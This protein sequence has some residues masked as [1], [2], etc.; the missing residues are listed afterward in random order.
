MSDRITITIPDFALVIL[1]GPSGSGKSSFARRHFLETEIIS[2]DHCRA[3]V[4]DDETDQAASADAFKLLH[5]TAAIR[6]RRRKLTVID[7]TSVHRAHRAN[8]VTLARRY[9]ALPVALVLDID[10]EICHA[11]N[12]E[13]PNRA[14]PID[15]PRS[16]SRALTRSLKRL[17]QEGFRQ[18]HIWRSPEEIDRVTIAREP[19][20]TDCRSETGPFD[21]I[22]DIHG[23][24]DEATALLTR[25]GY[26]IDAFDDAAEDLIRARHPEGRIAFFVGDLCDRGPRNVASLRLVMGM[27]AEGSGRCV[28]GNHDFKLEKWLRGKTTTLSHGLDVTVAELQQ[29]SPDFRDKV[30]HFIAG[31]RSHAWLAGGGLVIAHAGLRQEMHGRDTGTIR[32]F[33]M[34]GE[35]TGEVDEFG[36]PVR[37]EWA[38]SYNGAAEVV[39]GH[40]PMPEARWLNN[41]LCVDTGCVYGNKLTAFRWPEGEIVDVAAKQQYAVPKK[42]LSAN[43]R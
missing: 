28:I 42:P 11:R 36:L 14:F 16:H 25:L 43:A 12:A 20:P 34:F 10:P 4:S 2:S 6:L 33:A 31:L 32:A 18:I 37:L 26:T 23:C 7:A 13:R 21:I 41:T 5:E 17:Q 39:F 9:H 3:L 24:F 38:R 40:T 27:C 1:I 29:R 8:L 30:R 35:T 19:L 22:G 15:V